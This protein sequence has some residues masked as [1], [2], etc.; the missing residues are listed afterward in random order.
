[1]DRLDQAGVSVGDHEADTAEAAVDEAAEEFFP[2]RFVLR[3]TDVETEHLTMPV[4]TQAGGDHDRLGHDLAVLSD[5]NVGR[6]EP[7][8]DE[9]LMIEPTCAQHGDV[10]V[11]LGADP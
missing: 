1:L 5:M 11:D 9:R 3:V 6:V 2:E 8:V 4:R 7:D 10:S